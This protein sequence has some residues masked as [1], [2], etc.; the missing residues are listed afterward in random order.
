MLSDD[1]CFRFIDTNNFFS[2]RILRQVGCFTFQSFPGCL[3]DWCKLHPQIPVE[4]RQYEITGSR[5]RILRELSLMGIT[6]GTLFDDLDHLAKDIV[7]AERALAAQFL[8]AV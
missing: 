8:G 3:R 1:G 7:D 5:S 4:F 6:C 2:R